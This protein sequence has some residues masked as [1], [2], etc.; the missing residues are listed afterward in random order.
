LTK[1]LSEKSSTFFEPIVFI[2]NEIMSEMDRTKEI[3]DKDGHTVH[4]ASENV[5]MEDS[6]SLS[7][8]ISELASSSPPGTLSVSV[9]S[10]FSWFLFTENIPNLEL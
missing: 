2:K 4:T 5:T 6:Y 8:V 7:L 10:S 1:R 3:T 9:S